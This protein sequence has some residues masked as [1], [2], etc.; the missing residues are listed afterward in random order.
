[1]CHVFEDLSATVLCSPPDDLPPHNLELAYQPIN[2][3][4][5][6]PVLEGLSAS[7]MSLVSEDLSDSAMSP[8]ADDLSAFA[9]QSLSDDPLA[10]YH[11]NTTLFYDPGLEPVAAAELCQALPDDSLSGVQPYDEP[12][13]SHCDFPALNVL[14]GAHSSHPLAP[15]PQVRSVSSYVEPLALAP[16]P[17]F[18]LRKQ[19]RQQYQKDKTD[20]RTRLGAQQT[21]LD[22]YF[23]S[24]L[25][26][27]SVLPS[28]G[29]RL[30]THNVNG[31]FA[32]PIFR[33][34]S[35]RLMLK[36]H[37]DI[38]S[39]TDTRLTHGNTYPITHCKQHLAG[40]GVVLFP[41]T[42]GD[43]IPGATHNSVGGLAI[44]LS[45]RLS[46]R[47]RGLFLDPSN[48]G[49]A[50]AIRIKLAEK[51]S[52]L[53]ICTYWPTRPSEDLPNNTLWQ[54]TEAYLASHAIDLDPL[55]YVQSLCSA[56]IT[57]ARSKGWDVV[58]NGDFNSGYCHKEGMHGD[59]SAWAHLHGL[60]SKSAVARFVTK[61]RD[62]STVVDG[63]HLDHICL[64]GSMLAGTL[65]NV[66]DGQ[67]SLVY[68]HLPL[69]QDI[70]YQIS[71]LITPRT[72]QHIAAFDVPIRNERLVQVYQ[73]VFDRTVHHALSTGRN[74]VHDGRDER[75]SLHRAAET[76]EILQRHM[77]TTATLLAP[78]PQRHGLSLW[79]PAMMANWYYFQFL[80]TLLLRTRFAQ[81]NTPSDP[82]E[83]ASCPDCQP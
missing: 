64:S 12:Y 17:A 54:R 28:E 35:I 23:A 1:M 56:W 22:Q 42:A 3:L 52:L 63:S 39:I 48:L 74:P 73:D 15:I 24:P 82:P 18:P 29:I 50:G 25:S 9:A 75:S 61:P 47:R 30:M 19:Y 80:K 58:I 66:T 45:P 2:T 10:G 33:E 27:S 55:E 53:I 6:D 77:V 4:S 81:G 7:A 72:S 26:P 70:S 71:P 49:L 51:R 5:Y 21:T 11:P 44:L 34:E 37:V 20:H 65:S 31:K 43:N 36:Y 76:V 13:V 32:Q 46:T 59:M 68:D 60:Y 8:V 38:L 79:S 67:I 69:Y 78:E 14:P 83:A 62:C 40:G 57:K 41:T 16:P